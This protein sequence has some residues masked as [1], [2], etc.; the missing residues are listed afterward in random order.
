[1]NGPSI[2]SR[3]HITALIALAFV[4]WATLMLARG[5]SLTWDEVWPFSTVVSIVT[6]AS[7]AFDRWWWKWSRF[8]G[9]FVKVPNISGTWKVIINTQ[10]RNPETGEHPGPITCY[11]A[12]RQTYSSL[13]MRLMTGESTSWLI[14]QRIVREDDGVLYVTGV[15]L[16]RPQVGLRGRQSEIVHGRR[17]E[18]HHGAL[19]LEVKGHPPTTLD[20]HYWTDRDTRGAMNMATR[21]KE[22]FST[23]EEAREAFDGS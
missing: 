6:G 22:I 10:W 3:Q 1:M 15:Y 11:M 12:V 8:Q 9:W 21:R 17:S 16:N 23:Y 5:N 2:V 18:I 7:T 4:S 13:S 20:G 14:A 19:L